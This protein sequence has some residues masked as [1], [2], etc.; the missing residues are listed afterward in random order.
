MEMIAEIGINHN[1]NIQLAKEMIESASVAGADVVKFQKR[2]PELCVPNTQKSVLRSTPWGVLSYINYKKRLEFGKTEYD[3]LDK[4]ADR[5]NIR[6]SASVWDVPSLHFIQDYD[7]PFLKI[8]SACVA[9]TELLEAAVESGIPVY[10]STGM[11]TESELRAAMRTL[12]NS[13]QV[14]LHC[15]S[16]YPT[17]DEHANLNKLTTLHQLYPD[18]KLGYS[19]HEL[20]W[21]PTLI[22]RSLG[23]EVI[24]RHF[25]KD[26]TLWGSDQSISLTPIEFAKL[27]VML[28]SIPEMLGTGKLEI[29]ESE[30]PAINKLRRKI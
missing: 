22:A 15:V 23:A 18:I 3:V 1:G 24:E 16:G 19:G 25:T 20:G 14:I 8:P 13:V 12:D 6:W 26:P 30:L 27:K 10:L 17:P 2:T 5:Y 29:Q 11:T 28:D 9:H 4:F 21:L 7:V